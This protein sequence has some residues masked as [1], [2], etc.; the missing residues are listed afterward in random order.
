LFPRLRQAL[1]PGG[2]LAIK[3]M[4]LDDAHAGPEPA[5]LFGL[6]M[7]MYTARGRS[8]A[9]SEMRTLL[10]DAGFDDVCFVD[11]LDQHFSLLM[12]T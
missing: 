9:R 6:T 1:M 12:A 3:D 10:A 11:V 4:F 5:A 8:H 7:L 2:L